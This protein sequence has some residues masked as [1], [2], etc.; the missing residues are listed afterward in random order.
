MVLYLIGLGLGDASDVTVRGLEVIKRA[1][2][3]WLESYTA[4]LPG[5][6]AKRLGEWYGREVEVADRER[7][8][9][10]SDELVERARTED[11]AMLVVG[12][13]FG[14]TTHTDLWLRAK[15]K[16]VPVE[17]VH[18]ASIMN[19]VGACGLSLYKF[20]QTVSIPLFQ[21]SWRPDSFYDRIKEN[22]AGRMHTLCLLDIKVKEPNWEVLETKHKVVYDPPYF[23]TTREAI[24]QLLEVEDKRKEG[25][26]SR[27][28]TRCVALARVGCKDQRIVSGTLGELADVDMGAP[29]H[30]LV[31]VGG[32][33]HDVEEE[34][35][36]LFGVSS[37]ASESVSASST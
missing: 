23:M 16:G 19:A 37:R 18:N 29:L 12:D 7:V 20:G 15:K 24:A 9:Q 11:V 10:R 8:E 33:L 1:A 13:P 3:V 6:D 32:P 27:T 31:L 22:M 25:V 35:L 30:S 28:G 5:M 34:V 14:A 17:V 2:V 36:A 21:R 4:V 26:L